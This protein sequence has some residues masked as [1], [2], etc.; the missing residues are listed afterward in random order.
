MDDRANPSVVRSG[1][2]A[3]AALPTIS[4]VG[5]GDDTQGRDLGVLSVE[6]LLRLSRE[7]V[8]ELRKRG[9]VRTGN[10][11]VG[12]YAEWLVR[13]ITGGELAANSTKSHDVVKPGGERL[14]VKCRVVTD[15]A[16]RSERQ[17]SPF[18][19]WDCEAVVIVL[20]DERFGVRRIT[21]LPTEVVT[22]AARWQEHVRGWIVFA[23]DELLA[24]DAAIEMTAHA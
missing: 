17:L 21:R 6:E 18:R 24:T 4:A 3:M 8:G 19:S 1:S 10:A 13:Q 22:A 14:Q 11:P 2:S 16:K 7:A 23:T 9:V 15:P 20:F 5:E 12:D